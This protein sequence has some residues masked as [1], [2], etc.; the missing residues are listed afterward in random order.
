LE[1]AIKKLFFSNRKGG[2][3]LFPIFNEGGTPHSP[4]GPKTFVYTRKGQTR[5]SWKKDQ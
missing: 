4:L 2:D 3:N 5:K 1:L